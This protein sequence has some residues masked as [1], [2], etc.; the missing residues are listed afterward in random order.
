MKLTLRQLE[1]NDFDEIVSSFEKIG[2]N[3]P[4]SIYQAYF[5]EQLDGI[6]TIILAKDNNK[7]CGM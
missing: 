4:K 3:K 6:R 5:Q 2:W 1:K 7:F